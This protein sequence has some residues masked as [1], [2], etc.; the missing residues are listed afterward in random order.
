GSAHHAAPWSGTAVSLVDL[1]PAGAALSV[2]YGIAG[3]MQ[4]GYATFSDGRTWAGVWSGT[5]ASWQA[6]PFPEGS[7]TLYFPNVCRSIWSD[8]TRLCAS[9]YLAR[10]GYVATLHNDSAIFWSRPLPA[11]CYPNCDGS[12]AA[13]VLNIG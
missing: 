3:T 5:A 12:T 4:V 10:T 8:G 11:S 6:L 2:A 9:G 7:F 13:P 1:N